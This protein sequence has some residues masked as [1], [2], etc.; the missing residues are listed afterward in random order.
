MACDGRCGSCGKCFTEEEK[1]EQ[2]REKYIIT[3]SPTNKV[4]EFMQSGYFSFVNQVI[5][6]FGMQL[7]G[8]KNDN[9]FIA[10]IVE[11]T[12]EAR[13]DNMSV[14]DYQKYVRNIIADTL[15]DNE[16]E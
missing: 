15:V 9:K 7:K 2:M 11:S 16:E 4:D 12:G 6:P 8:L 3:N 1:E 5:N 13:I 10:L 14:E